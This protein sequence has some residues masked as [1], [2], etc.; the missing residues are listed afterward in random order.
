[1]KKGDYSCRKRIKRTLQ[2]ELKLCTGF[3]IGMRT[4]TVSR[5]LKLSTVSAVTIDDG[6][7]F[8]C[9]VVRG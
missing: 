8:H 2:G 7:W 9:M 5:P 6:S 3:M 1:M 4:G